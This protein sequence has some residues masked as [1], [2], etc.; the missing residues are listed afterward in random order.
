MARCRLCGR[1]DEHDDL[2][3]ERCDKL[4][5]DVAAGITM[6][7][8]SLSPQYDLSTALAHCR[9]GITSL[10]SDRD[11]ALLES[12]TTLLGTMD[13]QH[14]P[15]AGKVRFQAP[16]GNYSEAYGKLRQI[17][18]QPQMAEAGHFGYTPPV[19]CGLRRPAGGEHERRG[20]EFRSQQR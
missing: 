2:Y 18:W 5:G 13:G 19:H 1:E 7:A 10:Y 8:C 20:G 17:P 15:S 3:C 12:G 14:T 11:A 4:V 6:L 16:W 9:S